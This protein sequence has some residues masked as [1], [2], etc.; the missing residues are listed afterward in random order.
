MILNYKNRCIT[1]KLHAAIL[2]G[3]CKDIDTLDA[4]QVYHICIENVR[5]IDELLISLQISNKTTFY[6]VCLIL[7]KYSSTNK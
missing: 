5:R 7:Y 4:K 3:L 1:L 6:F 2:N